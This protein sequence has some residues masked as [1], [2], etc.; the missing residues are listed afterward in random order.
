MRSSAA[1]SDVDVI[2]VGGGVN[3]LVCA[4]YL[5]QSKRRV[6]V[7]EAL[8]RLGGACTTAEL[9][10]GHRVSAITHL[11]G[12]LDASVVKTLR[13]QRFGLHLTAKNV[14]TIALSPDGRHIVLDGDLRRTAQ[15]LS[16]H[17]VLDAKAWA[18][19]DA[20]F[21]KAVGPL[22]R[23]VQSPPGGPFE[24]AA[25]NSL[26]PTRAAA[27]PGAA[28]DTEQAAFLDGSIADLLD[29]EFETPLLK[30]VMAFNAVLGSGLGP[31]T[32]GTAF[33]AAL[34]GALDGEASEGL[35]HPQGGAGAF[36][37]ALAKSAEAAG[38]RTRLK[39][40]VARLLFEDGRVAGVELANG[41]AIRA[42][43]VV[44]SLDPRTT[45]LTLGAE[46]HLPIGLKRR[47]QSLR[48][49]GSIAKV[50]LAL[51]A[52][53]N[54]KGLDRRALR[55]RLVVCPSIDY[56][57]R[58]FAAYEQGKFSPDPALE[59][60]IPSTHDATL[61]AANQHVLSAYVL[62]TPYNLAAG[63]WEKAKTD[64]I[65]RVGA[66]LRQY[67]PDLPDLILAADV[68][69]PPDIERLAGS[70]GG[71]WHGGDLTLDQLGPLR[72]A[73]G[74]SRHD[75]PVAGL[76]LCGAG[77]HP[78]GGVTGINGRNAAEAVLA[79]ATVAP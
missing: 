52:L 2:V 23:W 68:F 76:F 64:L 17:S 50:N 11:L 43:I 10:A 37:T 18:H 47:L 16:P 56:L 21:R 72:P 79:S 58:A 75:T 49:E 70:A 14:A 57:E 53:P 61:A 46:R 77:T 20:R 3:G 24:H 65:A 1:I 51:S 35:V 31:R 5:A 6:V 7:V 36:V 71:H 34:R 55:E 9:V 13:L 26:F 74:M 78:C 54:F 66:T 12:P 4:A 33:L 42:P 29:A 63:G 69:T 27:K 19:F 32:Q 60:T 45:L 15:S 25:R 30:G 73:A 39:S 59:I 41:E 22:E 48:T 40:R 8:D 62:Y 44:S 38:V 28:L 67:A